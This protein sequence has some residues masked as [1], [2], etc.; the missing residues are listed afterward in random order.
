[1]MIDFKRSCFGNFIP[2]HLYFC[3]Y[4]LFFFFFFPKPQRSVEKETEESMQIFT[5]MLRSIERS[6]AELV[7]ELKEKRGTFFT[8]P[9]P[10]KHLDL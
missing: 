3:F 2:V 9:I 5:D 4:G 8:Q 6:Q 7:E 1:M 10:N